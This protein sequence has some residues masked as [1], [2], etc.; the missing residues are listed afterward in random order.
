MIVWRRQQIGLARCQLLLCRR[1]LALGFR[2]SF[3]VMWLTLI[4]AET[5]RLNACPYQRH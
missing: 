2:F 4:V 1:A 5:I 3:G